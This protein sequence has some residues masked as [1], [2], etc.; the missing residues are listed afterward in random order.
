[1]PS[2][3]AFDA[4]VDRITNIDQVAPSLSGRV[5][6]SGVFRPGDPGAQSRTQTQAFVYTDVVVSGLRVRSAHRTAV[7]A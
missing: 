4:T 1:M 2:E 5:S 6:L 7:G 3:Q